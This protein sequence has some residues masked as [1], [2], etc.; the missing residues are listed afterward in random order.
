MTPGRSTNRSGAREAAPG[1][2]AHGKKGMPP[3][4]ALPRDLGRG[5]KVRFLG[6]AGA[7]VLR[8]L[9]A[10]LRIEWLNPENLETVRRQGGRVCY[11]FWHGGL[12][13]LAYTHRSLGAVVLISRHQD[14]EIIAQIICR[15]GYGVIRGSSSRDG[16]RG[17]LA[18]ARAGRAGHPLGVTP[19]GPRGPRHEM[20]PGIL[21]IAARAGLP[22]V[23][24][25]VEATRR[26]ELSS[27]D[28]FLIPCPW[29]RVAVVTG[30][31]IWIPN[32]LDP[33]SLDREWGP[34]VAAAMAEVDAQA[35]AWRNAT[36]GQG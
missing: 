34:R 21:Q 3:G 31:P 11:A 33:A 25:A 29:S 27:W 14:G 13:P 8:L 30:P 2:R 6:M 9:G 26:K 7:A 28:R 12:L 20:Q 24:V 32:D 10:T 5:F 1:S 16:F 15:L 19:D 35:A 23:P 22:V 36:K 17:L 4:Q 18:M